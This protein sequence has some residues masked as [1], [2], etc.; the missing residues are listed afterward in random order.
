[1]KIMTSG[2]YHGVTGNTHRLLYRTLNPL[3]GF[4]QQIGFIHRGTDEPKLFIAGADLCGVH[5][6]LGR[7]QPKPG[8]YHIGGAGIFS[9]EALIKCVGE[10]LERYSQLMPNIKNLTIKWSSYQEMIAN[11]EPTLNPTYMHFFSN[12]QLNKKAFPFQAFDETKP[13]TWVKVASLLSNDKPLY[14]PLQLVSVGYQVRK[15]EGEPWLASA[16]TTGTAVH[17]T[18]LKALKNALMELI[19]LDAAMGQWYTDAIAYEIK[20]DNRTRA[21]ENLIAKY[22]HSRMPPPRFYWLKNAD[23]GGFVVAC[24]FQKNSKPRYAVGLGADVNLLGAMYSAFLEAAGVLQL[25]KINL[26]N[27]KYSTENATVSPENIYNL[28]DNVALYADN[29]YSNRIQTSFLS[30]QS[31]KASEL[32][33]DITGTIEEQVRKLILGFKDTNKDLYY[34]ESR[35]KEA[36]DLGLHVARVWSPQLLGLAIPSAVPKTHPRFADYGKFLHEDPH[37]YP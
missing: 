37:P 6:P 27:T 19:Q 5:V 30:S 35:G 29:D 12:E 18:Q 10:S 15:N 2:H 16:V 13:I 31:I 22:T 32:P 20:F 24:L 25:A 3:C 17:T 28:D 23:L 21:I 36:I 11:H 34:L 14:I 1:M 33:E 26:L 4:V 9:N 8:A 7:Q